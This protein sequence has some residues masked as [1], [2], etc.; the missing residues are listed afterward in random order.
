MEPTQIPIC[1]KRRQCSDRDTDALQVRLIHRSTVPTSLFF[2]FSFFL[3]QPT[4]L[5]FS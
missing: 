4:S 2:S 1:Q 3:V 5:L